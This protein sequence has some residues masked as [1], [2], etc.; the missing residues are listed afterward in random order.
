M[1]LKKTAATLAALTAG[2]LAVLP[3]TFAQ[4]PAPPSTPIPAP[5]A[6]IPGVPTPG[7]PYGGMRGYNPHNPSPYRNEK[8]PNMRAAERKLEAAMDDLQRASE[9][10]GGHRTAAMR[11][12]NQAIGQLNQGISYDDTHG[13][14]YR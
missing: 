8:Q 4:V 3:A 13:G 7:H 5:T 10:K 12:I 14:K 6:P 1:T 9:D 2:A 11:L